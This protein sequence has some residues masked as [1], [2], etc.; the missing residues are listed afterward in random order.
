LAEWLVEEGIGETRAILLDG[1]EI[2]AARLDWPGPLKAGLVEDAVLVSRTAGS[3]R[4]TARFANGEEAL[5]DD[6][7][8]DASEGAKLRLIVTRAALWERLR[9][10]H[11]RARPT[12]AGV[13]VSFRA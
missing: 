3:P 7:P 4:G 10:K 6:L 1:G 9:R 13:S 12:A 8:R 2:V 11:A 5:V